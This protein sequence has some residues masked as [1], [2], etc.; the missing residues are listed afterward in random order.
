MVFIHDVQIYGD[1]ALELPRVIELNMSCRLLLYEKQK[2][3]RLD[4]FISSRVLAFAG[5][6][7]PEVS[8]ASRKIHDTY[9]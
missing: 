2:P 5:V 6:Q 7:I 1:L 4:K 3:R 9:S 8:P